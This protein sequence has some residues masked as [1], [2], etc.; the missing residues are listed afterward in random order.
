MLTSEAMQAQL[1]KSKRQVAAMA[2]N[3]GRKT[4]EYRVKCPCGGNRFI[5]ESRKC[6]VC[7]RISR[8]KGV[9]GL[10]KE[11]KTLYV[12]QGLT[13]KAT[14][15]QLGITAC[16][17]QKFLLA[18]G[19]TRNDADVHDIVAMN[20]RSKDAIKEMSAEMIFTK[21]LMIMGSLFLR[22]SA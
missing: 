22:K 5:T 15:E 20:K 6:V 2:A 18:H 10:D 3:A 7:D 9:S 21:A 17:V 14:A 13:I 1:G 8:R 4:F 12:K 16:S 11:V 19:L